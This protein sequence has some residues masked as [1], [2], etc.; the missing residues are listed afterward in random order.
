MS[1]IATELDTKVK[2]F[3][4]RD[5]ERPCPY[6]W[7]DAVVIKVREEGRVVSVAVVI[8][9]GARDD[10]Q[11]EVLGTDVITVEDDGGWDRFLSDLTRRGL[12]GVKLSSRTR[13]RA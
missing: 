4:E 12:R 2:A 7:L 6:V 1:R 5:L 3:R 13:I 8:A 11:R 9:I 10:G